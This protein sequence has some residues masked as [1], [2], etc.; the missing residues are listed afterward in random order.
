MAARSLCVDNTCRPVPRDVSFPLATVA[1]ERPEAVLRGLLDHVRNKTELNTAK[2]EGAARGARKST[3][4]CRENSRARPRYESASLRKGYMRQLVSRINVGDREIRVSE[5][6]S[7]LAEGVLDSDSD[8][9]A[10]V[11]SFVLYR[12]GGPNRTRTEAPETVA[13]PA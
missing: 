10:G 2:S 11:P 6:H 4:K 12:A 5:P 8:P 13:L 1:P 9:A 7:G 3:G